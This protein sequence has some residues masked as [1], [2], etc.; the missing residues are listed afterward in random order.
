MWNSKNSL[1]S[2]DRVLLTVTNRFHFEHKYYFSNALIN[3]QSLHCSQN[4]S[5]ILPPVFSFDNESLFL[6]ENKIFRC[7]SGLFSPCW[8][9]FLQPILKFIRFICFIHFLTKKS[10]FDLCKK[11]IKLNQNCIYLIWS[12]RIERFN[13]TV[14]SFYSY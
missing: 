9:L 7:L 6:V 12:E 4:G 2:T 11:P 8:D 14:P 10:V 5:L 3:H 1:L 13:C